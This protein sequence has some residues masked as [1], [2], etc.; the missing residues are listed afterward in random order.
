[1]KKL[2]KK[3]VSERNRLKNEIDEKRLQIADGGG[4]DSRNE[5]YKAKENLF[6]WV[7][8]KHREGYDI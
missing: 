5:Y 1:M 7:T 8:E 6:Y 3:I 2:S 4:S